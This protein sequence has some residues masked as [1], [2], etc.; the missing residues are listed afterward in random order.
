MLAIVG[1]P[2]FAEFYVVSV[3]FSYRKWK[4]EGLQ[5]YFSVSLLWGI[6]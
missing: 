4:L 5:A 1:T 3:E 6:V 2:N